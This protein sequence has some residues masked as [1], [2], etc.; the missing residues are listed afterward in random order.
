[1]MRPV[2]N[3]VHAA[4]LRAIVAEAGT[5]ESD[6]EKPILVIE[7]IRSNDWASAT[8]VGACH[9]IDIRFDGKAAAV[10]AAVDR[11]VSGLPERDIPICGH[12][13]AEIAATPTHAQT[14]NTTEQKVNLSQARLTVNV[15]TILD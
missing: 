7:E 6:R 9:E 8:F 14:V 12:I 13:V 10:A 1:M 2:G 3:H 5:D 11:L 4:I 15:L